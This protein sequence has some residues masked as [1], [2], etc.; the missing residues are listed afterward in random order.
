MGINKQSS[1][2][3]HPKFWIDKKGYI[4][5]DKAQ[6]FHSS[7]LKIPG[8]HNLQN[9]LLVTAAAREIGLAQASIAK[10]INSFKPIPHRLEYLGKIGKLVIYND[11][12]ATNFDSSL[13]ALKSVPS[14]IILLAGGKLKKGDC[15]TWIEQLKQSTKAVVLF[16]VSA[17][18]LK[19]SIVKSSYKGEVIIKKSLEEAT[20]ASIN[21]ARTTNSKTILLS[22]ACASFDQ[23]KSYEERGEHF[24]KIVKNYGIKQ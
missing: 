17:L 14:P 10:S 8:K 16:G 18:D 15:I 24:K 3:H 21:F 5:E 4:F 1:Y 2:S 20:K 7:I 19:K 22:P 12:K 6:L 11:S 9:L 23:Y 13:T